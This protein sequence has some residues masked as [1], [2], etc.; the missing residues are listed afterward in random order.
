M[1]RFL[2]IIAATAAA[3]AVAAAI[4][5]P[6]GAD[7]GPR[8]ELATFTSCLRAHGLPVPEGLDAMASKQWVGAHEGSPGFEA[9][10]NAC[11]P[12]PDRQAE[13][14]SPEELVSCLREHGLT[15]PTSIDELKP[16]MAQQDGT[17]AGRAALSA[18][19]V[20]SR[21]VDKAGG[22]GDCAGEKTAGAAKARRA[23]AKVPT[24]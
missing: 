9:A 19:G 13:N 7:D 6:A 15:P 3:A 11:D 1:K 18:C 17:T 22:K 5:L 23:R 20:N 24:S 2:S 10:M 8:D 16:W 12:K 21:P 14:S 4:S